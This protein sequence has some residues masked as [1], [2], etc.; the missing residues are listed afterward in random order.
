MSSFLR[1]S[2]YSNWKGESPN[3]SNMSQSSHARSLSTHGDYFFK[4]TKD[5]KNASKIGFTPV[6]PLVSNAPLIPAKEI[7]L[8]TFFDSSDIKKH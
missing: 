8:R 6:F 4:T 2:H 7:T 1:R 5:N 3:I